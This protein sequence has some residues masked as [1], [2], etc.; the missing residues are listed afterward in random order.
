MVFGGSKDKLG[1]IDL[2][3]R[4]PGSSVASRKPVE[5]IKASGTIYCMLFVEKEKKVVASNDGSFLFELSFR[6]DEV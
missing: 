3:R 1:I 5:Y 6:E 4:F 2:W